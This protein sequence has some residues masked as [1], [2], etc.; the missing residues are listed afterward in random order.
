MDKCIWF[1]NLTGLSV[2]VFPLF[3]FQY[4][5]QIAGCRLYYYSDLFSQVVI[6]NVMYIVLLYTYII[7]GFF[8]VFYGYGIHTLGTLT[9]KNKFIWKKVRRLLNCITQIYT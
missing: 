7:F 5:K 1:R 3:I 2:L 6:L 9:L 4:Y 8:F